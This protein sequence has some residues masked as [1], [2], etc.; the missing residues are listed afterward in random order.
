MKIIEG[1]N[2]YLEIQ[3]LKKMHFNVSQISRRLGLSRTTVYKYLDMTLEEMEQVLESRKTRTKKLDKHRELIKS[4]LMQYPDMTSAQVFDWLQERKLDGGVSEGTVRNYVRDLREESGIPQVKYRRQYEAVDELPAGQ[5]IQMDFGQITL[6]SSISKMVT[7]Y[8]ATFV[9]AHS[10][11][12]YVEWLNRPFTTRDLIYVHENAFEYY[13]GMSKEIVYDQDHLIL[14]SENGG[15]LLLTK[16][17]AD[18]QKSRKFRIYMCRKADPETKGKVENV[19]K[20][21]KRN[22]AKNRTF[23]NLEKLNEDCLAWLERTGNGKVHNTTKKIPAEVFALEKQ[24]FIPVP[25]KLNISTMRCPLDVLAQHYGLETGW[26]DIT[27]NFNVALFFATCTYDNGKWRPLTK[28]DTEKDEQTKYGMLFH[29]PS[30][31]MPMRWSMNLEKF[32]NCGDAIGENEKGETR[33]ELLTHPKYYEN[34]NNLMYPIGFQ[35][36]MRCSMQDGYGIYMRKAQPL[37]EDI[38]F[39]K[40]RFRHSEELSRRVFERMDGGKAIYPHEGLVQT[41]FII[42]EIKKSTVFSKVAFYY[43]LK[44]S[45]YYR[46]VDEER[47]LQ[48]LSSFKVKV[49][50]NDKTIEI[51]DKSPWKI[52]SGRRKKIDALY[53]NFSAESFYGIRILERQTIPGGAGMFEPWMQ[54]EYEYSPGAADY[55]S[56]AMI[57]CTNLWTR[58][59]MNLLASIKYAKLPDFM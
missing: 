7:L 29:M 27:S 1:W 43:A 53:Q 51:I 4:W 46:I 38:G 19:V 41:Q 11:Y 54:L 48:D 33:Y 10:R 2:M 42:D 9:L 59:Y 49:D 20:Y 40:L 15:D 39:Q 36:F 25:S 32:S 24:Y 50:V 37:Q 57:G 44:K 31:R 45:Q 16:E 30:N 22:F 12:K 13:G 21:V 55:E 35:P 3:D 14:V 17:F 26:L 23:H 34:H 8:F 5:Q 58:D 47:C 6:R 56:R 18:Y 28:S 52:S